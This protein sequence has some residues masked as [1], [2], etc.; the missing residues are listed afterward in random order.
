MKRN[1]NDLVPGCLVKIKYYSTHHGNFL[2]AKPTDFWIYLKDS[3]FDP[4]WK[5]VYNVRTEEDI[6]IYFNFLE[7]VKKDAP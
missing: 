3:S 7:T 1:K 2:K 4:Q 5:R 6:C